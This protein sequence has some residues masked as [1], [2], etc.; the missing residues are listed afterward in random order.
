MMNRSNMF[1]TSSYTSNNNAIITGERVLIVTSV[2][3]ERHAILRGLKFHPRY[4]VIVGGVGAAAAAVRTARTL[5]A[6]PDY[7]LVICAGIGGGFSG[8]AE[9]GSLVV[10][11]DIIAADLGAQTPVGFYSLDELGLGSVCIPADKALAAQVTTALHAANLSAHYGPVL[12]VTTITGTAE[13]ATEM[14]ARI[15]GVIAEAMEGYGVATA[16]K[17]FGLPM[18]ELRAISNVVGP[19]NRTAWRIKE[20]LAMLEA[21]STVLT[22][23]L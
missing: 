10:A 22:E 18:L 14:A 17:D 23:V 19:R 3:V 2:A 7:C 12:T 13:M 8:A 5:A 15:P 21:A 20:A 16:T 6:S 1:H 9:V 4:N 11:S